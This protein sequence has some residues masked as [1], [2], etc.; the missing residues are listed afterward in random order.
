LLFEDQ[1]VPI[2]KFDG[3]IFNFIHIPKCGG[4][5][6]ENYLAKIT[7]VKIDFQD[8]DFGGRS[9]RWSN[10][11]PQ[12]VDKDGFDALFPTDFFDGTF[13]VVR[14]PIDRFWS[15]FNHNRHKT[16]AIKIDQCP[17]FFVQDIFQWR[18]C[19]RGWMDNHFLP[20]TEF[21]RQD[22]ELFL[23]KMEDGLEIVKSF[24]DQKI[25]GTTNSNDM[26]HVEKAVSGEAAGRRVTTLTA[27]SI[28]TIS[29]VYELDFKAFGYSQEE[30]VKKW[31]TTELGMHSLN[32]LPHE[33]HN[34]NHE[35]ASF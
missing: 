22:V 13:T 17:N 16:G 19:Q 35:H 28:E 32:V 14:N 29:R 24:I 6:I 9:Y 26:P 5:S 18:S 4:S 11:S 31:S 7:G 15:A 23:F 34:G 21:L 27:E 3:K 1:P 12:H 25:V 33:T 10:S 30:T 20:Q 8:R 2:I